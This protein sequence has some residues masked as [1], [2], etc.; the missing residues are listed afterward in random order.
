MDKCTIPY[1]TRVDLK[2]CKIIDGRNSGLDY[3]CHLNDRKLMKLG[4]LSLKTDVVLFEVFSH[5]RTIVNNLEL[6]ICKALPAY[7]LDN[8]HLRVKQVTISSIHLNASSHLA[9]MFDFI[10][11]V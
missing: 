8:E 10:L 4:N 3:L 11:S 1:L 2:E 6:Q 7:S 9:S 5:M